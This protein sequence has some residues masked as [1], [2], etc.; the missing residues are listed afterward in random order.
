[1]IHEQEARTNYATFVDELP[2]LMETHPHQFAVFHNNANAGI[3]ATLQ[4]AMRFGNKNFGNGHF[5]VQEIVEQESTI[6]SYS[7][8]F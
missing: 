2:K 5:I 4:E 6:P 7:F 3:F 1:M 8:V